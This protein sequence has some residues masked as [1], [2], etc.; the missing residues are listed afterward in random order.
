MSPHRNSSLKV[1]RLV[2]FT[3]PYIV[4]NW[5]NTKRGVIWAQSLNHHLLA[6]L[7]CRKNAELAS[8]E[9]LHMHAV[10]ETMACASFDRA[11]V[12]TDFFYS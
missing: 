6:M 1:K 10:L 8:F 3:H 9:T 2:L 11:E 12:I 5:W 7:F 4:P